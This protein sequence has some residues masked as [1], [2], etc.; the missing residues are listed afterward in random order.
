MTNKPISISVYQKEIQATIAFVILDSLYRGNETKQ[1]KHLIS[2]LSD[3][4]HG[5]GNIASQ[6]RLFMS[7]HGSYGRLFTKDGGTPTINAA[8]NAVSDSSYV[9]HPFLVRQDERKIKIGSTITEDIVGSSTMKT[10][11]LINGDT[12]YS[13]GNEALKN[14]KK[15]LAFSNEFLD[16]NQ[17]LPS[18]QTLED[19]LNYILQQMYLDFSK[20]KTKGGNPIINDD[21]VEEQDDDDDSAS[22]RKPSAM[23]TNE[24]TT[25]VPP[26]WFFKG[27]WAFYLFGPYPKDNEGST[28]LQIK[29]LSDFYNKNKSV[30]GRKHARSAKSEASTFTSDSQKQ[31]QPLPST[32]SSPFK[33]GISL[34]DRLTAASIAVMTESQKMHKFDQ[35][36]FALRSYTESLHQSLKF[37]FEIGK[38]TND[39]TRFNETLK[40]N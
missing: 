15:A 11:K 10:D 14:C 5:K 39:M 34:H 13:A 31:G 7:G 40:K 35:Q 30:V 25:T 36:I 32:T 29:D 38:T 12:L 2:S 23:E 22:G 18:G 17:N 20:Q 4:F 1:K 37:E 6:K 33:R 27:F 8:G 24:T 3:C 19:Y 16:S 21:L 26:G 28:L 9:I